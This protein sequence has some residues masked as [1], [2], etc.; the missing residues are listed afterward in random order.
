MSDST[1]PSTPLATT[2]TAAATHHSR[3]RPLPPLRPT[4]APSLAQRL[5]TV[6][7]E[8][9]LI[10]Q[11]ERE[12]LQDA[13][14]AAEARIT[15]LTTMLELEEI[16]G[17]RRAVQNEHL[18]KNLARAER[19]LK[20]SH[21]P[22][23]RQL[24]QL[25]MAAPERRAELV[26]A[27][28]RGDVDGMRAA[29]WGSPGTRSPEDGE[30]AAQLRASLAQALREAAVNGRASSAEEAFQLGAYPVGPAAYAQRV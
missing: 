19:A 11:E 27:S 22:L 13:L 6:A 10:F 20:T 23:R 1:T 28:T 8:V 18:S 12:Q 4:R 24:A 25:R 7:R 15:S 2:P 21:A 26:L 9:G 30:A 29:L 16:R 14:A 3:V 17:Q 5:N